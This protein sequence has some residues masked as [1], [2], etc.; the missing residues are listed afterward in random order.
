HVAR[1][2]QVALDVDGRIGEELLS[3]PGRALERLLELVGRHR[4]TEALT[5]AAAGGLDGNRVADRLVHDPGGVLDGVHRVGRAWH[6][7]YA[8]LL[9]ELARA[10]LGAHRVD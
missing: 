1:V 10:G 8:G 5:P 3:L 6:D 4:H 7:R 2:G 9:H